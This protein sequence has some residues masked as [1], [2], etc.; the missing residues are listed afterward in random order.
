MRIFFSVG[1]PSGDVHGAN[2]VRELLRHDPDIECVGFGG[3]RMERAGCHLIADLTRLA[4]MFL[5][6]VIRN[7]G[8][9]RR[10]LRDCDAYFR[11]QAV[12]A[13]VLIDYPG[14][15]WHVARIAKRHGIPV[16]YYGIPQIWAWAPWRVNKLR[17]RVDHVLSKLPFEPKWLEERGIRAHYVGHPFYDE[18]AEY[19][20][21]Q[22][23]MEEFAT[24]TAR[25]PVLLLLPGSRDSEVERNWRELQDASQIVREQIPDVRIV[26][27]CFKAAQ[28]TRIRKEPGFDDSLIET[29]VGRTPEL[30]QSAT[31]CIAVSGSVTLELLYRK[32]PTV[33]VYKLSAIKHFLQR[34]VIRA[35]Y[36]TLVNL[37]ATRDIR[38]SG[39]QSYDPDSPGSVQVPMPEY[40]TD[41]PVAS[42]VAGRIVNW[43][44]NS[45]AREANRAE[46]S[47]LVVDFAQT[48]ATQRGAKYIL[49]TLKG[50]IADA[51]TR[52]V[53]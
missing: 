10:Y 16:F 50:T 14:F 19:R 46:L 47:K 13:V 34:F 25:R 18:V 44:L 38:R 51:D 12:D 6:D 52:R 37:M 15:N 27:A 5:W 21:D 17:R 11:D 9:F 4:V 29:F 49:G 36:I 20:Y 43:L 1:E 26:V 24:S 40:L 41:R 33:V 2:L 32:V 8:T 53:A 3:A 23:F 31:C 22:T 35:K 28:E 7:Y 30:M 39:T 42:G 45:D 48:G